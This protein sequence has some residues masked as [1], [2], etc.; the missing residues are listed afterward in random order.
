MGREEKRGVERLKK[1]I[2]RVS[3]IVKDGTKCPSR[4]LWGYLDGLAEA[5]RIIEGER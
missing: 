4:W 3:K 5:L 2:I 1:E